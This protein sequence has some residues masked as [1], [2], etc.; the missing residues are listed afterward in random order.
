MFVLC[1]KLFNQILLSIRLERVQR[2]YWTKH[3]IFT[4]FIVKVLIHYFNTAL[5][6]LVATNPSST[7]TFFVLT[8]VEL[9]SQHHFTFSIIQHMHVFSLPPAQL[10]AL[11]KFELFHKQRTSKSGLYIHHQLDD[12]NQT[13]LSQ[14]QRLTQQNSAW[15]S[16]QTYPAEIHFFYQF[17]LLSSSV[18]FENNSSKV[19]FFRKDCPALLCLRR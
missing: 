15:G 1:P 14:F 6:H 12:K 3:I 16:T 5:K 13:K 10:L 9:A 11:L 17:P 4:L 18:S 7:S 2:N 8:N 19:F